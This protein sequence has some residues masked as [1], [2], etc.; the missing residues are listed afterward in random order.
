[1]FLYPVGIGFGG[2]SNGVDV[3]AY[4]LGGLGTGAKLK[5][6]LE[7]GL[8]LRA[9]SNLK[10]RWSEDGGD[11]HFIVDVA[12]RTLYRENN[13]DMRVE[14]VLLPPIVRFGFGHHW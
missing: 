5:P 12:A 8:S 4:L 2:G 14:N 6:V 3:E 9:G 11:W 1:M 13:A 7:A 10:D